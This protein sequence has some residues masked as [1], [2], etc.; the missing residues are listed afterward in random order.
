MPSTIFPLDS[1]IG[2]SIPTILLIGYGIYEQME[3][4]EFDINRQLALHN[5]NVNQQL[6]DLCDQLVKCEKLKQYINYQSSPI[7]A[8]QVRICAIKRLDIVTA[9]ESSAYA[10]SFLSI[11]PDVVITCMESTNINIEECFN[12]LR[13]RY[14]INQSYFTMSKYFCCDDNYVK[15]IDSV[16][17]DI[18]K[19]DMLLPQ[20]IDYY[21]FIKS[22]FYEPPGI[23]IL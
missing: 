9:I 7:E 20:T 4:I 8:A 22:H 19:D 21:Q 12:I 5:I 3:K 11:K 23:E 14:D 17:M 15:L 1:E 2:K 13:Y 6:S 16:S 10:S 18:E